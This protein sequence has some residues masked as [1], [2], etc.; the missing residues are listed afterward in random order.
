VANIESCF[1]EKFG[2]KVNF[3]GQMRAFKTDHGTSLAKKRSIVLGFDKICDI[4]S[5]MDY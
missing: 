4:T 1:A 3:F 5:D 2:V